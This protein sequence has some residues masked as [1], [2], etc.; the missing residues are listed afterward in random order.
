MVKRRMGNRDKRV[1][2]VEGTY[3]PQPGVE[4]DLAKRTRRWLKKG[5]DF[6]CLM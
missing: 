5:K 6:G 2:M 3:K 4:V 1:D